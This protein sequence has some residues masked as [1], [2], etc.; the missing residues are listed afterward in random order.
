MDDGDDAKAIEASL[1]EN[2]ARLPMDEIDQYKAFAALLK[3]GQ[4]VDDIASHFGVT[5]RL[6]KQRLAIANLYTP[7]LTAYR[8]DDIG[9]DT[10]RFLTLATMRQQK[11]WW[12]LF[13]SEDK[14]APQGR[15]LKEWLF[16][17]N[18]IP[19]SNALFD[20][21]AYG[22]NIVSDLFGEERYF[23]DAAQFWT[24]QNTAIAEAKERYL[25]EGWAM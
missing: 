21:D 10:L 20:V 18:D 23:D 19:V 9:A 7:L 22:G 25:A 8:K 17:G 3:N 4:S 24:L 11:A 1:A 5:E 12:A 16:G 14:H 13:T 2:I 6:V 15:N